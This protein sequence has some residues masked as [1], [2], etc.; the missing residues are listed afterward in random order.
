VPLLPSYLPFFNLRP[1]LRKG[2]IFHS[3][4]LP[5]MIRNALIP[6][7]NKNKTDIN[8]IWLLLP[9]H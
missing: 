4:Q 9:V 5:T 3:S 7:K 6:N 1:A 8:Q 2:V